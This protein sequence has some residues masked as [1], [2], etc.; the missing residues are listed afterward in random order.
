MCRGYSRRRTQHCDE[1]KKSDI[2]IIFASPFIRQKINGILPPAG[3]TRAVVLGVDA[4]FARNKNP[5]TLPLDGLT[6][7]SFISA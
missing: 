3:T 1:Y 2:F 5:A 4:A 7:V 6:A